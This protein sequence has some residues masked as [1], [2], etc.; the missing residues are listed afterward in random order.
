M[1]YRDDPFI[2]D[3]FSLLQWSLDIS[4]PTFLSCQ[5]FHFAIQLLGSDVV[6]DQDQAEYAWTAELFLTEIWKRDP[7]LTGIGHSFHGVSIHKK[8]AASLPANCDCLIYS[9]RTRV[10]MIKVHWK[11]FYVAKF[12]P[13]L[14]RKEVEERLFEFTYWK[15]YYVTEQAAKDF[16]AGFADTT[17]ANSLIERFVKLYISH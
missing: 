7:L 6:F 4:L 15:R 3:V 5:W 2:E 13:E 14:S 1:G 9:E 11:P 10:H 12:H 17:I 16:V 8:S